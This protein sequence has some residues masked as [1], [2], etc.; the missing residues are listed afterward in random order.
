MCVCFVSASRP[1]AQSIESAQ[2]VQS[3]AVVVHQRDGEQSVFINPRDFRLCRKLRHA[4]NIAIDLIRIIASRENSVPVR[5]HRDGP[6][7]LYPVK[8]RR[9]TILSGAYV[10]TSFEQI[11]F[12]SGRIGYAF[13]DFRFDPPLEYPGTA[14]LSFRSA[15]LNRRKTALDNGA[16]IDFLQFA[17]SI[18]TRFAR[19]NITV[20]V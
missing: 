11:E 1:H 8:K 12:D 6:I 13:F 5:A 4:N 18:N 19:R 3:T 16:P 10:R 15:V 9:T 17:G 14:L 2:E 20:N 7:S